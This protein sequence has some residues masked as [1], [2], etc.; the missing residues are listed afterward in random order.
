[1]EP[2]LFQ[3]QS[4]QQLRILTVSLLFAHSPGSDPRWVPNPQLE[5]QLG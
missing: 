4:Q 5:T 2:V 3:E 1:V